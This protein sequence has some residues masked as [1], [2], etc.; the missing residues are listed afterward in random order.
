MLGFGQGL[1]RADTLPM[2]LLRSVFTGIAHSINS[3]SAGIDFGRNRNLKPDYDKN[4]LDVYRDLTRFLIRM[5]PRQL[6]VL[7][8][9]QHYDD[10]AQS[11]FP[12]WV[13]KWFQPHSC[14]YIGATVC[15]LAGLCDGHFRYYTVVH[16]SPLSGQSAKPNVL[17]LDGYR[18]DRVR[19]V[20]EVMAFELYD[21][22]PLEELWGQMFDFP[23]FTHPS[24]HY[25]DGNQLGIA[26]CVTLLA[27]CLGPVMFGGNGPSWPAHFVNEPKSRDAVEV[28]SLQARADAAA[29][30]LTKTP[31][32]ADQQRG[33]SR[34]LRDEDIAALRA[35]AAR[36]SY[37]VMGDQNA[38]FGAQ[39]P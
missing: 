11:F 1:Q 15:F 9:V 10:P 6:D 3:L 30:L 2:R 36:S 28:F 34:Y 38:S 37:G 5:Q 31:S 8:Y 39:G 20:S 19:A 4:L 22:V 17:L 32:I 24:R 12:S 14:S 35:A 26:F 23:L 13:P 7:S 18:V 25:H 16:D 33:L 21:P 29:Y 27:D